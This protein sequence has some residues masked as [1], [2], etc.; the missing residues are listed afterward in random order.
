MNKKRGIILGISLHDTKSELKEGDLV[1]IKDS[2]SYDNTFYTLRKIDPRFLKKEGT[3]DNPA[4]YI[5]NDR[6]NNEP[7]NF[8]RNELCKA[9][10]GVFDYDAYFKDSSKIKLGEV[11]P[12]NM[13][14]L[15]AKHLLE[16]DMLLSEID[17]IL[18]EDLIEMEIVGN[19]VE[20]E[21]GFTYPGEMPTLVK[22]FVVG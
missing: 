13:R 7:M 14:N 6:K 11:T 19:V 12:E 20:R 3:E 4:M 18:F 5:I 17:N 10:Y 1:C 15:K 21:V 9:N 2:V 16:Q 22:Y 8:E